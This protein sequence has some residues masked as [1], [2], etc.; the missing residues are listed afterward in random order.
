VDTPQYEPRVELV[1][2]LG[3]SYWLI[4]MVAEESGLKLLRIGLHWWMAL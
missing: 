4:K 1:L 3:V 2:F